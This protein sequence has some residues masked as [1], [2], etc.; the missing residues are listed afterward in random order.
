[1][2][3]HSAGD[4]WPKI[5]RPIPSLWMMMMDTDDAQKG[6]MSCRTSI[7]YRVI[8]NRMNEIE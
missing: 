8:V 4:G 7:M 5:M 6:F 2:V 3:L 1:M